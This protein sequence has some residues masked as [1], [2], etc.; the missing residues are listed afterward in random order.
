MVTTFIYIVHAFIIIVTRINHGPSHL[1]I[2]QA[3]T[4][5]LYPTVQH[6]VCA[7][8]KPQSHYPSVPHKPPT[9]ATPRPK[10]LSPLL[11]DTVCYL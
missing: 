9:H 6:S 2:Y 3:Q 4:K 1:Q 5:I 10:R 8:F 7:R 11:L